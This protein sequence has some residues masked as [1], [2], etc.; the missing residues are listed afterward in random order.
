MPIK[1]LLS[2]ISP[3]YSRES[4]AFSPRN[5][6]WWYRHVRPSPWPS[7][8]ACAACLVAFWRPYCRRAWAR[9]LRLPH[10]LELILPLALLVDTI[11]NQTVVLSLDRDDSYLT[12]N[13]T[14]FLVH[15]VFIVIIDSEPL[16]QDFILVGWYRALYL[17]NSI[18][19]N[20]QDNDS[21]STPTQHPYCSSHLVAP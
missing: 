18:K 3:A 20:I 13:H 11:R 14:A 16:E 2:A 15:L 7:V 5:H 10:H 17:F 21:P 12:I 1:L 4:K 19:F 9:F 6:P 8:V